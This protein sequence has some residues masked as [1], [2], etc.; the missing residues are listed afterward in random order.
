MI[1]RAGRGDFQLASLLETAAVDLL[2]H[3]SNDLRN[4][5]NSNAILERQHELSVE[6]RDLVWALA[7]ISTLDIPTLIRLLDRVQAIRD[8]RVRYPGLPYVP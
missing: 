7:A 2:D 3:P 4:T 6:Q 8:G 5:N 1:D